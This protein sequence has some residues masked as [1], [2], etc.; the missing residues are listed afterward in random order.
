VVPWQIP[1]FC[2]AKRKPQFSEQRLRGHK[3]NTSDRFP[4]FGTIYSGKIQMLFGDF[5]L[6]NPCLYLSYSV[7][8]LVLAIPAI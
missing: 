2:I 6:R 5:A 7:K 4:G 8:Q 3:A 1:L